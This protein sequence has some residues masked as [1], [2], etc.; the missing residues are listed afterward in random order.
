MRG[1]LYIHENKDD[2][3]SWLNHKKE[4]ETSKTPEKRVVEKKAAVDEVLLVLDATVG[5]NGLV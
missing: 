4:L 2:Y 1:R 3:M 5:Q